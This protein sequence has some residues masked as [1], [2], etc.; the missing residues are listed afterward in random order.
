MITLV[1][2]SWNMLMD[3]MQDINFKM[4]QLGMEYHGSPLS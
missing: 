3:L 4:V 2:V 1:G